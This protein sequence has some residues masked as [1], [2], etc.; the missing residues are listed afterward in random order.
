MHESEYNQE[1][2]HSWYNTG[3]GGKFWGFSAEWSICLAPVGK[4]CINFPCRLLM[5]RDLYDTEGKYRHTNNISL[6]NT[7]YALS[8]YR[9][10]VALKEDIDSVVSRHQKMQ[11]E[12]AEDMIKMARSLKNNSLAAK[13]IIL[14]DNKVNI[15]IMNP[16]GLI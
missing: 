12:I 14:S 4:W 3:G 9:S 2:M 13:E 6:Q 8:K 5:M 1:Y 10:M 11:D 7:I 15:I 16:V